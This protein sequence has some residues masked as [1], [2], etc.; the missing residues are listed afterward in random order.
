MMSRRYDHVV[1]EGRHKT[2]VF[3]RSKFGP[4]KYLGVVDNETI[5]EDNDESIADK[6]NNDEKKPAKYKFT[7]STY[8]GVAR[9]TVCEPKGS[10]DHYK[11]KRAACIVLG[12]T[13]GSL[14]SGITEHQKP[15]DGL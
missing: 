5:K 8:P 15:V 12:L 2:H 13:G 11:W 14:G 4:F 10:L 1:T 6:Y 7:V 9:G 3:Y